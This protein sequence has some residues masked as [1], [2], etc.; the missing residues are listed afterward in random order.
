MMQHIVVIVVAAAVAVV[1]NANDVNIL[2]VGA[3]QL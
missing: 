1:G 2:F 3:L